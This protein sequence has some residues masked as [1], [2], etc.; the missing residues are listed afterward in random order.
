MVLANGGAALSPP[1]ESARPTSASLSTRLLSRFLMYVH[2]VGMLVSYQHDSYMRGDRPQI[3]RN[4]VCTSR[5]DTSIAAAK[6]WFPSRIVKG[7]SSS[8]PMSNTVEFTDS[9]CK[10]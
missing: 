5:G 1:A 10:R 4:P 8:T 7:N 9:H 3:M 2:S 6:R